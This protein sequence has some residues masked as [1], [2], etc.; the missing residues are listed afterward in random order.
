MRFNLGFYNFK[1]YQQKMFQLV[2]TSFALLMG[3]LTAS[4][5][6]LAQV[7]N[8]PTRPIKM[9]VSFTA[10]GTSDILAREVAM[11][12]TQRLKV[13]VVVEI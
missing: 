4:M 12:L 8:Y 9:I 6:A 10:G 7:D 13:P 11:Q 2:S 5:N 3:L 1:Q